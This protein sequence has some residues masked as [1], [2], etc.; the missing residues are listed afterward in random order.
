MKLSKELFQYDEVNRIYL[1]SDKGVI[2]IACAVKKA[3][4]EMKIHEEYLFVNRL[5]EGCLKYRFSIYFSKEIEHFVDIY[6][7]SPHYFLDFEYNR[8]S[9]NLKIIDKAIYDDPK[10]EVAIK[11]GLTRFDMVIHQR[12]EHNEFPENLLHFEFKGIKNKKGINNDIKRVSLT[13]LEAQNPLAVRYGVVSEGGSRKA[14]VRG[15]QLGF[16]IKFNKQDTKSKVVS[17]RNGKVVE[18]C[19]V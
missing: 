13:T 10:N 6:G 12:S 1:L 7:D 11:K 17:I 2:A 16:V 19:A 18:C 9:C 4:K 5:S 15:Y 14:V 8:T 3:L